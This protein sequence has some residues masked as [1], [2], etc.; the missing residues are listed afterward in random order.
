MQMYDSGGMPSDWKPPTPPKVGSWEWKYDTAV[1]W[2]IENGELKSTGPT[3]RII[4]L[5]TITY[6]GVSYDLGYMAICRSSGGHD[7][8][9]GET[10]EE[11]STLHKGDAMD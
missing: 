4:K 9:Y 11:G 5:P 3:Q 8:I 1:S 7:Y 10:I 6:E 2:I